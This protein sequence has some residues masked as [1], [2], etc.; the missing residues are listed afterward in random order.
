MTSDMRQNK[1]SIK[2]MKKLTDMAQ[3]IPQLNLKGG[4]KVRVLN[5]C[6]GKVEEEIGKE[7]N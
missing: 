1:P 6:I 7:E 5:T 3:D 4:F 2:Q